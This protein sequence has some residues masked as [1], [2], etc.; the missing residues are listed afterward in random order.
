MQMTNVNPPIRLTGRHI[1][2]TGAMTEYFRNKIASLHL[3]YPKIIEVHG[4]L[5]IA[6]YRHI[7]EVV[8]RCSNHITIKAC[9]ESN[10]MYASIDEVIDRIARKMRK[11]HTRLMR[12]G[13]ARRHSV[14]TGPAEFREI[15]N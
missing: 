5:D 13:L 2:V 9:F 15:G 10:D 8:M 6:K 14:R 11:S 3:E 4:I 1:T 12:K 7:A